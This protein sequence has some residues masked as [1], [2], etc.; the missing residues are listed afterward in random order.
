[1][2]TNITHAN[3]VRSIVEKKQSAVRSGL[4][5]SWRRSMLHYGLTPEQQRRADL[6]SEQTLR[7]AR[8]K[9]DFLLHVAQPTLQKLFTTVDRSGCVV[10]M[11][12]MDGV[13]IASQTQDGDKMVF[14]QCGLTTGAVWSES[15]QGT[16]GIGTCAAEQRPIVIHKDQHFKSQNTAMSCMG[17]PVFDN[18]GNMIAVLDVSSC[19]S[20]LTSGFANVFGKVVADTAHKIE[21]DYFRAT[22]RDARIVMAPTQDL[23]A[24]LFAVDQDELVIGANR[25]ARKAFGLTN[26][27]I[28]DPRPLSDLMGNSDQQVASLKSAEKSEL[29]RALARTKGNVS[30]AAKQLGISRAT[31]YRRMQ[32]LDIS[33]N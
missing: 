24:A 22:Y 27:K 11:S 33:A 1:M 16:N 19:R 31:M 10:V 32:R 26:D 18:E 8:E 2:A 29:R 28:A 23:N 17:A 9:L 30:L 5:A 15:Q 14:D 13:I 6:V 12:D 4:A 3:Y 25:H 21:Q 20:D 7:H